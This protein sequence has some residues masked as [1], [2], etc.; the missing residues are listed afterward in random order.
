MKISYIFPWKKLLFPPDSVFCWN[1]ISDGKLNRTERYSAKLCAF[2]RIDN[3]FLS[4]MCFESHI[5]LNLYFL[6]LIWDSLDS[7]MRGFSSEI[8]ALSSRFFLKLHFF[9]KK[10]V[11]RNSAKLCP[12]ERIDIFS[13]FFSNLATKTEQNSN[14]N[15]VHL[16]S[17]PSHRIQ[18]FFPTSETERNSNGIMAFVK[19][20]F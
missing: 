2:D 18:S 20:E 13:V 19:P 12:F 11:E 16:L 5:I 17:L 10:L 1:F 9:P 15:L 3:Y 4:N 8:N 14:G 7:Q 6:R